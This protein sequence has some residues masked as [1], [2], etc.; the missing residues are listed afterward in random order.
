MSN[1]LSLKDLIKIPEHKRQIRNRIGILIFLI[2]LIISLISFNLYHQ[3]MKQWGNIDSNLNIFLLINLNVILLI[4]VSLLILRNLIK[5]IYER[6]TRRLGFRLKFKLTLAFILV[7]TL[8]MLLFLYITIVFLK[9]SLDFWFHGQ[10]SVALKES[11]SV[12]EG[13]RENH[14]TSLVHFSEV[15]TSELN[16]NLSEK[17]FLKTTIKN[18]VWHQQK[19]K[20]YQLDS[21]VWYNAEWEVLSKYFRTDDIMNLWSP[22]SILNMDRSEITDSF[23]EIL[24]IKTGLNYRVIVPLKIGKSPYYLELD[25]FFTGDSFEKLK[26]LQSKLLEHNNLL[27]L[28]G[29]IR[30]NYISYL[31]LFTLLIV[32]AG[33]W[34][35]YYLARSI[36]DPIEILVEGTHRI[37][38]GD[39]D[40]QIELKADD[41]IGM[42]LTS[43][44][45]MTKE[46]QQNRK[47]LK[48]SQSELI[49]SNKELEERNIFVELVLQ[50]IQNGIFFIDNSG[51]VRGINPFMLNLL[52]IKQTKVL[53]RH[54][55][56]VFQKDQADYI[57]SL[58]DEL[59]VS[60][61]KSIKKSSHIK[62]EKKTLHLSSE[63]FQLNSLKG[64]P[65][66]RLLVLEDLSEINRST[67]ARAWQEVAR[68]IAHEIKNPLTPIQLSAQR[69]RKKYLDNLKDKELL[70]NCTSIII[71]EVH[72]LKNMVNEFS[73]FAR[74]P[75]INPS[76]N[77]INQILREV[78]DLFKP[79]LPQGIE[80]SLTTDPDMPKIPLDSE[81]IKRVFTNLIDNS[82]ASLKD[83][84]KVEL[85]SC[86]SKD[87]K[88]VTVDVID[89]GCGIPT[90][91]I[92]R[93]FDP[94]V[95]TKEQGTGLGLAIVQQI[96]TDHGG[97]IRPESLGSQ[98]TKFTIELPA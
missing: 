22:F 76:P 77:N 19:I 7:S 61:E 81:Q 53:G 16:K 6:K 3:E 57:E 74:L 86:F 21:F 27:Y 23:F 55:L 9:N 39:L 33:T 56:S 96:I 98:G 52:Q 92:T 29:P 59:T 88:I 49:N 89:S 70:D 14:R 44:N 58:M 68:R 37:S 15:I 26:D 13:F 62:I 71:N 47:E 20:D 5:L 40:F 79:G 64:I 75:E 63:I 69:I 90:D 94:Y 28:E 43:F 1:N 84:G 67:R 2:L 72:G 36:V 24:P 32:F 11:S 85:I 51:Y 18:P 54:Y 38:K 80:L 8:P 83:H 12:I 34:F 66:G 30:T 78:T 45:T 4:V 48:Q 42:L 31:L 46:L 41:E 87:L 35:G 65:I 25:K 60:K 10:Y 17:Q 82:V 95:T 50:N 97:F 91:M 73:K 93:I